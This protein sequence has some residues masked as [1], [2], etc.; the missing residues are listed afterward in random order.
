MKEGDLV[1]LSS[2]GR[3]LVCIKE[4]K[5]CIGLI[6]LFREEENNLNYKVDWYKNGEICKSRH[7]RKDLKLFKK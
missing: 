2:Y 5:N 4:F 6:T 3:K 1:V 7:R